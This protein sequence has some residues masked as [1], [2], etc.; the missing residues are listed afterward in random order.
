MQIFDGICRYCG[1][2]TSVMAESQEDADDIV[3]MQCTCEDATL[4]QRKEKL[5]DN[6]DEIIGDGAETYGMEPLPQD[7]RPA[8]MNIGVLV[9]KEQ[10][11][12]ASINVGG[13]AVKIKITAKGQVKVSRTE[14]KMI[15]VE[16]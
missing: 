4:E 12:A 14:G 16:C 6:L 5:F 1:Q 13:T 9:M 10:I 7:V 2:L 11:Q 15:G 3:T 8:L